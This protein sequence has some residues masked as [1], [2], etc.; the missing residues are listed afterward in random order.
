MGVRGDTCGMV[1][2]AF[3]LVIAGLVATAFATG[4]FWYVLGAILVGA[5]GAMNDVFEKTWPY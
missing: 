1:R 3:W 2:A 4:S 5:V